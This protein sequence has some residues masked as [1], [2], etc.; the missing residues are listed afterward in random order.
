M[1]NATEYL[2]WATNEKQRL[3]AEGRAEGGQ[4]AACLRHL[5]AAKIIIADQALS[6]TPRRETETDIRAWGVRVLTPGDLAIR[7]YRNGI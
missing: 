4:Y 2:T 5:D 7:K 1:N 3:E 6:N